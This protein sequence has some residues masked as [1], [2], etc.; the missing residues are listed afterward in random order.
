MYCRCCPPFLAV[1]LDNAAR[2]GDG[3]TRLFP[4]WPIRVERA[5]F[6][7][8]DETGVLEWRD[9]AIALGVSTWTEAPLPMVERAVTVKNRPLPV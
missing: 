7:L 8:H 2:Q 6:C 3:R 4:R 9:L 5:R 1:A